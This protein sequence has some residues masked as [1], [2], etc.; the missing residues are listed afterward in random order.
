METDF[1]LALE[2]GGFGDSTAVVGVVVLAETD[3]CTVVE[4]VTGVGEEAAGAS[5]TLTAVGL[6]TGAWPN[7]LSVKKLST[8]RI[9][10]TLL[11]WNINL[12]EMALSVRTR[13]RSQKFPR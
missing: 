12:I 6:L 7:V 3:A 2:L 4:D 8:L 11:I 13:W 5:L 1:E 9:K 10:E